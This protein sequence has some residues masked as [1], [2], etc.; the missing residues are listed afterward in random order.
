M[1]RRL[2]RCLPALIGL[3]FLYSSLAKMGHPGQATMALES[4]EIPYALA[5]WTIAGVT[6]LEL[7]LGVLLL[8]RW[9]LKFA[10]GVTTGLMLIFTVFLW[11]L[12]TLAHPPACGCLGLTG[13]F[14]NSRAEALLGVARNCLILWALK[15]AYDAYYPKA[16][17][18]PQP[19]P[20]DEGRGLPAWAPQRRGFTLIELLVVIAIIGILAALLLPALSR[21]KERAHA[22]VCLGNLRQTTL[23]YRLALDEDS[24]DR[25][26]EAAVADWYADEVGLRPKGWVCPAAQRL[27]QT[28]I[29]TGCVGLGSVREAW[30]EPRWDRLSTGMFRPL[31]KDRPVTP[32]FRSGSYALNLWLLYGDPDFLVNGSSDYSDA[33]W[34]LAFQRESAIRHPEETPVLGDGVWFWTWPKAKDGP[35]PNLF[36]GW[37][38]RPGGGYIETGGLN[39]VSVPR[40]GRRPVAVPQQWP[41]ARRLPGGINIGFFDGHGALVPLDRLWQLY[42]HKDYVPPAKRPGLQ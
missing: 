37:D 3:L 10:L 39:T 5:K 15:W 9:D 30:F 25:L 36:Y 11:Y 4:L 24:G 28:N 13:L 23:S 32:A 27:G 29:R 12:S 17:P 34:D 8:L 31:P 41:A 2:P 18:A 7:Y 6:A 35:P 42:W 40:H 19:R 14:E 21:A 16:P 20:G 1:W 33:T 22:A 38:P 26:G